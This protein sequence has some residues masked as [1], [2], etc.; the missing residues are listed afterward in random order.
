MFLLTH[1]GEL[2][3]CYTYKEWNSLELQATQQLQARTTHQQSTGN[4]AHLL[5][6]AALDIYQTLMLELDTEGRYLFLNAIANQLRY[7]NNH[8]HYF[9]FVLLYL[10][11]ESNQVQLLWLVCVGHVLMWLKIDGCFPVSEVPF[12]ALLEQFLPARNI[13][14]KSAEAD[15]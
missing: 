13:I 5:L 2:N 10:F 1:V 6:D 3:A 7:P 4:T 8:T 14:V 9:S 15:G 11:A 12:F